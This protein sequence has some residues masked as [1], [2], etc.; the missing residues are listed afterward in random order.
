MNLK[1]CYQLFNLQPGATSDE[2][3]LAYRKLARMMHPDVNPEDLKAH[4][5]FVTLN[6]AYQL[7][8]NVADPERQLVTVPLARRAAKTTSTPVPALSH[9]DTELK[10]NTYQK[11]QELLRQREFVKTIALVDGLAQRLE[12]DRDVRQWQGI[13]YYFFGQHLVDRDQLDKARIYLKKALKADPNN[14]ELCQQVSHE[15]HRIE[16]IVASL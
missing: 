1:Q 14:P 15:Y 3:R 2:I 9:Y 8:L 11:L 10:W 5:R 4:N 6:Q 12:F 13:V 16:Q 7:L